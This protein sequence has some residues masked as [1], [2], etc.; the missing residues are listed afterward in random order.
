MDFGIYEKKFTEAARASKK[1]TQYI[2]RC[3]R[4]AKPLIDQGLPVIYNVDH[5]S[6]LVG[7]KVEY[8]YLMANASRSFYRNFR[9]PKS[10]GKMRQISA[11]LPLLKDVQ[12]FI[13]T[14]IL[15]RMPCHPCAKAYIKKHT[16]KDNAKFHR[17]QKILLKIDIQDYFPSLR[18]ERVYF[19]FYNLGYT[20]ALSGLFANL[21]TLSG[22]LPQGAPTSPYLSNLLTIQLDQQLFEY[23]RDNGTLRYTRY[24][25]DISISGCFEPREVILNAY[26]IIEQNGLRPNKEKTHVIGQHMQQNVTGI[27]VNKKLQVSKAYRKRIR[28]DIYYIRKYGVDE[29]L[30]RIATNANECDKE[31][32]LQQLLGRVAYCLQINPKDKEMREYKE[33]ILQTIRGAKGKNI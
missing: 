1:S 23:C 25:D 32:Y 16:L 15:C 18:T 12:R 5:F 10:N 8:L 14:E 17:N 13:L 19:F 20:K 26:D 9:I 2:E 27:V 30:E 4:Y 3:L 29:H 11:P 21:C 22:G 28:A 31:L 7:V 33:Y 6:K 24:A